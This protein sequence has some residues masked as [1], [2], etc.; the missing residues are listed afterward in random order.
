MSFHFAFA[1]IL[2]V[3]WLLSLFDQ[4]GIPIS[5]I[6]LRIGRSLSALDKPQPPAKP[7]APTVVAR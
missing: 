2:E 7:R 6:K 1:E 5:N 3:F 4:I